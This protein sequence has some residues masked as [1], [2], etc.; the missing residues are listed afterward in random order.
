VEVEGDD[1]VTW[2]YGLIARWW[3]NFN[4]DG[5]EIEFFRAFVAAGQP[6]LDVACGTGRLLVPW[7]AAGLDVD[8]VDASA[9]MITACAEAAH[10]VGATPGL[11][12]Q[13]V[14]RLDVPRR[15]GTIVMCGGFGLGGTRQQ[16]VDRLRRM[17]AHLRPGGRLALDYEVEDVDVERWRVSPRGPSQPPAPDRRRHAPDGCDYALAHRVVDID[18]AGRAMVRE[19]GAW[20]WRDDSSWRTR[21]TGW[22]A[23]CGPAT[24]SS[25]ASRTSG[26][27]KSRWSAVTTAVRRAVTNASSSTSPA[28]LK[29]LLAEPVMEPWIGSAA[30]GAKREGSDGSRS[31]GRRCP[32]SWRAVLPPQRCLSVLD[33]L[34]VAAVQGLC[35]GPAVATPVPAVPILLWDQTP[36]SSDT[37]CP[38][39]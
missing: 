38:A 15:Y 31:C 21:R 18:R 24:R 3:A 33:R 4:V 1:V 25:P 11:Y 2:H 27:A 12:V 35:L 13:P 20:Q 34:A 30:H 23:T 17:F 28:A 14:H 6:A 7:V 37:P 32:N 5:P 22:C 8:G 19:L 26:S 9:D 39:E 36:H 29:G 10:T 16:D